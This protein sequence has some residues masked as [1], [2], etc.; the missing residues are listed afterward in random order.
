MKIFKNKLLL[1]SIT[2]ILLICIGITCYYLLISAEKE[3]S[4]TS[5]D[6]GVTLN[7]GKRK[8]GKINVDYHYKRISFTVKDE[9]INE[10]INSDYVVA[11][12]EYPNYV[13]LLLAYEG[14]F[15]IASC[16]FD[17]PSLGIANGFSEVFV[18]NSEHLFVPF[19]MYSQINLR[20]DRG[21]SP[22]N[23]TSWNNLSFAY[24]FD[25]LANLYEK[26][27][28]VY[29]RKINRENKTIIL[30]CYQ[31]EPEKLISDKIALK[32][33][34]LDDGIDFEVEYLDNE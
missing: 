19:L 5:F 18:D 3:I 8:T 25:S 26:L 9:L 4:I 28:N 11:K 6:N 12:I 21:S 30:N 27:G 23:F 20:E 33:V 1:F 15:F 22:P 16:S 32:I 17:Y 24:D 29:L 34:C 13:E 10:I 7:F 2:I 31:E 14:R